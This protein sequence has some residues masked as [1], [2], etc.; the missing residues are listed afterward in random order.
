ML[1][2]IVAFV[3]GT[4]GALINRYGRK[5]GLCVPI[6][7]S[8]LGNMCFLFIHVAQP[9][10]YTLVSVL[11]CLLMGVSGG[12]STFNVSVFSY[13]SDTSPQSPLERK[14]SFPM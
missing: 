8:V 2:F 11:G 10:C 9:Q 4:Y 12:Y 7:G 6:A 3:V 13:T 14:R 1:L 5:I